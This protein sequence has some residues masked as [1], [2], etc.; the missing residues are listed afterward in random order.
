[1]VKNWR[2][3]SLH[4]W[5]QALK[6]GLE[7]KE[8]LE[9]FNYLFKH[10]PKAA[11]E[12]PATGAILYPGYISRCKTLD[13]IVKSHNN[14]LQ[15]IKEL[16]T[17]LHDLYVI[18]TTFHNAAIKGYTADILTVGSWLNKA[19]IY[20]TQLVQKNGNHLLQL[21]VFFTRNTLADENTF[22]LLKAEDIVATHY[23]HKFQYLLT[24]DDSQS[25]TGSYRFVHESLKFNIVYNATLTTVQKGLAII[26]AKTK[27]EE[28][29]KL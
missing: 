19:W 10:W 28:T 14:E 3:K 2:A 12:L 24:A 8:I 23:V 11:E 22:S 1:M 15:N 17:A 18:Q 20:K 5:N 7:Y 29:T 21:P 26:L 16:Q 13:A 25:R 6:E 4:A 27:S 9:K